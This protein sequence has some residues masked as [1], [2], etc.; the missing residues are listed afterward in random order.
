MRN[1]EGR[2]RKKTGK[3]IKLHEQSINI[4][5]ECKTE[6]APGSSELGPGTMKNG[7]FQSG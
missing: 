7:N 3:G 4:A 6:K 1:E 5:S 2:K